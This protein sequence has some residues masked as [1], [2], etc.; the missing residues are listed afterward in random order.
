VFRFYVLAFY[1]VFEAYDNC[2]AMKSSNIIRV[3]F[4]RWHTMVHVPLMFLSEWHEFPSASCLAGKKKTWWQLASRCC[5]NGARRLTCFL[6]ASVTRKD[7]QFGTETDYSLQLHYQFRR[8][9]WEVGRAKDYQHP[10]L[11]LFC[12]RSYYVRIHAHYLYVSMYK[13]AK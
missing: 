3:S 4:W 12:A 8:T 11:C 1:S 2:P 5:W 9:T 13:V 10:I 7:L 6:S